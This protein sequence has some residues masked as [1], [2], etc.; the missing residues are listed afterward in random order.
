MQRA[1]VSALRRPDEGKRGPL[2]GCGALVE[3]LRTALLWV[4]PADLMLPVM[5]DYELVAAAAVHEPRHRAR[6][7]LHACDM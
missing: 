6:G 2:R 1:D 3:Q 4:V 5:L 7:L